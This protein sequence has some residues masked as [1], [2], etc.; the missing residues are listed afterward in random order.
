MHDLCHFPPQLAYIIFGY[1]SIITRDCSNRN[2]HVDKDHTLWR[3]NI[4]F[5]I[6][7]LSLTYP[8]FP[9]G[10]VVKNLPANAG[11]TDLIAG[12]GRA[13]GERNDNPPQYSCLGNPI[14]RGAWQAT[15]H[16]VA[17]VRYNLATKTTTNIYQPRCPCFLNGDNYIASLKCL[18]WKL[19]HV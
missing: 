16:R 14:D 9:G 7:A 19:R 15:V 5:W 11:D 17:K 18:I 8:E 13:P 12:S 3:Q 10:S 1:I 2:S 4:W 6:W